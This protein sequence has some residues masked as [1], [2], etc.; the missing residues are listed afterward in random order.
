MNIHIHSALQ[1][2]VFKGGYEGK[3]IS[4]SACIDIALHYI[5][6]V[7]QHCNADLPQVFQNCVGIKR[8]ASSQ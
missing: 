1:V 2:L 5:E 7:C 8:M 4:S 3:D 6:A